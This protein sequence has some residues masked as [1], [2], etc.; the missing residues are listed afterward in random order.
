MTN[1]QALRVFIILWAVLVIII[2]VKTKSPVFL[3]ALLAYTV[4]P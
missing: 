3:T 1:T 4:L 2:A